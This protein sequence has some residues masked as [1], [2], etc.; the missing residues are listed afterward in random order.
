MMIQN[1]LELFITIAVIAAGTLCTRVLPFL[2]FP[3]GKET[4][5]PVRWLGTVLPCASI[6]MLVVYCFK[7]VS[8]VSG[9]HGLPEI[10]ASAFVI[11]IHKMRHNLL[12]SIAGGTVLYMFL[13]QAV[14]R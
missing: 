14:F 3:S 6:G 12:L 7:N 11:V 4:P 9:T 13:V 5:A 2:L 10:I 8:V 1:A